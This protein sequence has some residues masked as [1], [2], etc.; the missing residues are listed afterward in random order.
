MTHIAIQENV[1]GKVVHW[2]EKVTND[3]YESGH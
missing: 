2:L 3:Q 1:D